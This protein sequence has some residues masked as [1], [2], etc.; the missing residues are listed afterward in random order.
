M[1]GNFSSTCSVVLEKRG[2]S[3]TLQK[4]SGHWCW[5]IV[6]N[7]FR[8][9]AMN[10]SFSFKWF[11]EKIVRSASPGGEVYA[12][13]EKI[14]TKSAYPTIAKFICEV[15]ME[16]HGVFPSSS[17]DYGDSLWPW[18]SLIF[19]AFL[20]FS[21]PLLISVGVT[22]PVGFVVFVWLRSTSWSSS[23]WLAVR[24]V[25]GWKWNQTGWSEICFGGRC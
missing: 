11:P 25:V 16:L 18:F 19:I 17:F 12:G 8:A 21:S 6:L 14:S 2:F 10:F 4:S 1:F 23:G 22:G 3:F 5:R 24:K 20:K 15:I 13:L 7:L 9:W